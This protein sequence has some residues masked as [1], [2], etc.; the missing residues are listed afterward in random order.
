MLKNFGIEDDDSK[1]CF[2]SLLLV[3]NKI[4][5]DTPNYILYCTADEV[6]LIRTQKQSIRV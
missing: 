4:Y 5:H 2:N 1:T 6:R 3:C